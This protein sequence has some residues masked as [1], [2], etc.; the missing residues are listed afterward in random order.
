MSPITKIPFDS[1]PD[2][3]E[4]IGRITAYWAM[5]EHHMCMILTHL[6]DVPQAV[7]E[8]IFYT[9]TSNRVRKDILLHVANQVIK[10]EAKHKELTR[11]LNRVAGQAKKRNRLSHDLWSMG[12]DS[13]EVGQIKTA[14]GGLNLSFVSLAKLKRDEDTIVKIADELAEFFIDLKRAP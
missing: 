3:A 7:G 10:D 6:L 13:S 11:L 14:P 4:A 8:A 9:I 2:H 12:R 5:L 1:H